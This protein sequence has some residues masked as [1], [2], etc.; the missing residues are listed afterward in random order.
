MVT[1]CRRPTPEQI[2]AEMDGLLDTRQVEVTVGYSR[3][4]LA[5]LIRQQKFPAPDVPGRI[6]SAH[7]W[8]RSTIAKYLDELAASATSTSEQHSA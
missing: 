5:E 3:R 4:W 7:R 6:G 2:A 1:R 8:R